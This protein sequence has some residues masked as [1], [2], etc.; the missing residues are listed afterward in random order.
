MSRAGSSVFEAP[1]H[2]PRTEGAGGVAFVPYDSP[3]SG[4]KID[5][6]SGK[7]GVQDQ[8]AR[9]S[10]PTH[11]H[12]FGAENDEAAAGVDL[13]RKRRDVLAARFQ[14]PT[15]MGE[16]SLVDLAPIELGGEERTLGDRVGNKVPS[17]RIAELWKPS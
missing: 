9:A 10:P 5:L 14:Q 7:I 1:A 13:R 11:A 8:Q 17:R 16:P 4:R 6:A 2:R 15:I 12:G 3:V